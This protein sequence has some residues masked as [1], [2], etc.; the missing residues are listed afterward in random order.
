M[1]MRFP[2]R[3]KAT[4]STTGTGTYTLAE[5]AVAGW[6]TPTRAVTDGDLADGDTVA[7]IVVDT[8]VTNGPKLCEV[9]TGVWN[10]TA[11]T[12]TRATVLQPNGAAVNWGAGTRDVF[13]VNNPLLYLMAANNLSDLGTVA[14]ARTN[15][16]LGTAAVLNA[17]TGA[18]QAVQ[19]TAAGKLPAVPGD[20]LTGLN[21]P[22]A[23]RVVADIGYTTTTLANITGLSIAVLA[24]ETRSFTARLHLNASGSGGYKAAIA[25]TATA[26]AI[27]GDGAV[28]KV[29]ALSFLATERLTAMG[30]AIL[31]V[32]SAVEDGYMEINGVITVNA[33]GTL[34]VQFAQNT[35]NGTTT[36]KR[37]S[38]FVSQVIS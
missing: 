12:L 30:V 2:F 7:Y 29:T 22:Q 6:R 33:G 17:G 34:T 20:L 15:L 27:I 10:N 19:L 1:A 38:T 16:G 23:S 14:T 9:G 26:T 37:G 13:V 25:G 21:V 31:A 3:V 4:T 32:A 18:N 5:P 8:T 36:V 28:R 35:A 11:K 24:G